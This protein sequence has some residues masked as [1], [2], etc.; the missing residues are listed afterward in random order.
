[1]RRSRPDGR[2]APHRKTR[3]PGVA[4]KQ[5]I[6]CSRLHLAREAAGIL[7]RSTCYRSPN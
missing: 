5:G 2:T 3:P 4:I 7:G 6:D 1:M